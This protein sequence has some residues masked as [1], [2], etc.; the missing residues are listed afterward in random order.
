MV[1]KY[2]QFT[3][4]L[5]LIGTIAT[6]NDTYILSYSKDANCTLT[7]NGKKIPTF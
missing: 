2:Y 1:I 5:L 6:A 7:K 4:S 3:A